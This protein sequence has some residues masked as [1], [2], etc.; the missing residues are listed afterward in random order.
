VISDL[1]L[2]TLQASLTGLDAR[3][4]AAENNVANVETSGFIASAVSFEDSLRDAIDKGR[5]TSMT[6]DSDHT[7]SPTR[8]NGNNVDIADE[9]VA[10]TET[11]LRHQLVVQTLNGKY[12][13]MRT[14]ING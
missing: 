9:Q 12:A 1:T 10:L 14:A 11:A 13:A 3:R 5:P 6:V 7:N 4:R 2:R 8:L